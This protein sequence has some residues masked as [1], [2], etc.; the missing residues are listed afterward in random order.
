[1]IVRVTLS[2]SAGT[3]R[4]FRGRARSFE[5]AVRR[6]TARAFE[7]GLLDDGT[8]LAEHACPRIT[9]QQLIDAGV[10]P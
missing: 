2:T 3:S 7:I 8:T 4:T 6:A 5:D 10:T 9:R 1:M